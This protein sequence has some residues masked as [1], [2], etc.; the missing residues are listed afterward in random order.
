ME[1]KGGIERKRGRRRRKRERGMKGER[2]IIQVC[3]QNKSI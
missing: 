2:E 3:I 1:I